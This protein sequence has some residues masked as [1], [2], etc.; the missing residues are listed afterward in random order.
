M[1]ICGLITKALTALK[2]NMIIV[3]KLFYLLKK[4]DVNIL[5]AATY[6]DL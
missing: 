3:R 2:L 5:M 4:A 1:N 6:R